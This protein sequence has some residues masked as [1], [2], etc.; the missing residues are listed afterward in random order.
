[1]LVFGSSKRGLWEVAEAVSTMLTRDL[2]LSLKRQATVLAPVTEGIGWLG[3]RVYP[4]TTRLDREGRKRFTRK[5]RR[6]EMQAASSPQAE[7]RAVARAA[8]VFGHLAQADTHGLRRSV[9]D[10]LQ[11]G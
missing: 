5:T 7:D 3:F 4:G 6:L 8:S 2:R 11:R 9:L 1:M 10:G